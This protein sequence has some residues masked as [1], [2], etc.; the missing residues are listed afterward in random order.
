NPAR[1]GDVDM[2]ERLRQWFARN[3]HLR[4]PPVV[5][6]LTHV[7]LLTP[8]MEW[9]PP[10][11]WLHPT[12]PKEQ[13]MQQALQVGGD[14]FGG[15]VAAVVP[16]CDAPGKVF[17]IDEALLPALSEKL[18]E[19]RTVALLRVLKAEADTGRVRKVFDQLLAVGKEAARV[20]W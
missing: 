6:V 5:G 8:A 20:L 7:D 9:A 19:A 1:Q 12:R 2:L 15:K 16:V 13:Q 14:Q 3:P 11:D 17:G 4:M 10:Y 18:G